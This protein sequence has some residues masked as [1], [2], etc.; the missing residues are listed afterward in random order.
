MPE[1]PTRLRLRLS[2]FSEA[3][4]SKGGARASSPRLPM[5]LLVRSDTERGVNLGAVDRSVDESVVVRCGSTHRAPRGEAGRL[6]PW[7]W[8]ARWRLGR[9]SAIDRSYPAGRGYGV[10]GM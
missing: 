6:W 4:R 10:A 8:R 5:P 1:L 9:P 2:F 7:P 3:M